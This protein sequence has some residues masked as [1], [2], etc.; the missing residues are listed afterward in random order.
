MIRI[1]FLDDDVDRHEFMALNAKEDEVTLVPVWN[2][3]QCI[4]A[5][6]EEERFHEIHLDHDLGDVHYPEDGIPYELTGTEVA[7]WMAD[8]LPPEK[9]PD[10]VVIHSYNPSGAARMVEILR[11]AEFFVIRQPFSSIK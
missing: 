9:K 1:L 3:E 7:K 8:N 4:K 6:Q 11:R 10:T 5:L 2:Y